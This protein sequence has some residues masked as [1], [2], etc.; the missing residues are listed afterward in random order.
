MPLRAIYK[1]ESL[2]KRW[3]RR[4]L[5]YLVAAVASG[6]ALGLTLPIPQITEKPF[7]V[8]F[9]AGIGICSWYYGLAS[10]LV[11][12]AFDALAL[13]YF[14]LPP[15]G[16][17]RVQDP[18]DLIRLGIFLATSIAIAVVVSNLRSTR[19]EL[20]RAHER[21]Q[22]AHR[23]ARIYCWELDVASGEVI[24][25]TGAENERQYRRA[26]VQGHFERIHPE[27]RPR[28]TNAL[29][30]AVETQGR[31]E[32]EYRVLIPDNGVRW[33]ASL[34]E[35]HRSQKGEPCVI[36]VNVDITARKE[37]EDSREAAAKGELAGELAH[38]INN[39]LQSL[40]HALYLVHKAADD[41]QLGQY[42]A[43]A[44]SEAERVST[45]L[46]QILSLYQRPGSP[47]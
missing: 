10:G 23:I 14:V 41:S 36:G 15:T 17:L 32:I 4:L 35:F 25:S 39:P 1:P 43:I 18:D 29:K 31:Y 27:D 19:R 38:Q 33:M 13:A 8:L 6:A 42:T 46:R 26:N 24:W 30:N 21:F 9:F 34:G 3:W 11:S 37:I 5:P 16:S 12:V 47:A 40:I 28:L 22:L 7:F 44:Q 45:L 2:A 20:A